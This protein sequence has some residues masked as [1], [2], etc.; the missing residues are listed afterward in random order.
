MGAQGGQAV[1]Q[2]DVPPVVDVGPD[3]FARQ[4][5][6]ALSGRSDTCSDAIEAVEIRRSVGGNDGLLEKAV[7]LF[8]FDV[9]EES[10]F[11]STAPTPPLLHPGTFARSSRPGDR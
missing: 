4:R 9:I 6:I 3:L 1:L 2:R 10:S 8:A 11:D 5:R 7:D